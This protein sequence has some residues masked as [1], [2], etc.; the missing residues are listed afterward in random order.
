MKKRKGMWFVIGAAVIVVLF[1]LVAKN[2]GWIGQKPAID[3]TVEKAFRKT[4]T[5]TVSANGKIQPEVEVKMSADV[6]GEIVELKVKEGDVIKKG[7][8]LARINPDIYN[9]NLDKMVA[10]VNGSKANLANSKARKA[11]SDAQFTKAEASQ[12]RNQKLFDQGTISQSDLEASQAAF[13]VA[14][15]DV[16]A[17]KQSVVASEF[18]VTNSEASLKEATDQL[19]KTSIFAPVDGTVSKLNVEKGERVVGTSQMAGTEIMRIADLNEMEVNVDVNEN[20]I[21]H[22]HLGDTSVI[23]VDAYVDRKFMG[24]VTEIANSANTVGSSVDQVTNFQVKIRILRDSY[25]DI[26]PKEKPNQSPFRPGM[27]A[28]VDIQTKTSVN[29]LVIPI[30]AATTRDTSED[31]KNKK[32]MADKKDE[33]KDN[34]DL[35]K[36]DKNFEKE[37]DKLTECVFMIKDGKAKLVPIKTGIQDNNSIE[38]LTGVAEGDEVIIEPYSAISKTLKD[39]DPV[40]ITTKEKLYEKNSKK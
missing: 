32:N 35:K 8:L 7:D 34:G 24:V 21:V 13:D 20:D 15:Q 27:T 11:Q 28:T 12:K 39:G 17:A 36:T 6:S 38:V 33:N 37:K 30:K 9:S 1:L 18:N 5:E 19:L 25:Q 23:D 14:K 22:V 29:A 10:G 3:V 31:A 40:K 16:E 26:I 2:K 4:V